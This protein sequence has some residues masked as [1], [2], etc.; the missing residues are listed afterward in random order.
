LFFKLLDFF[1]WLLS[2]LLRLLDIHLVN[3]SVLIGVIVLADVF[4]LGLWLSLQFWGGSGRLR[5]LW[6]SL[7]KADK[8]LAD[9]LWLEG[10]SGIANVFWHLNQAAL[11]DE[12]VAHANPPS[13][14]LK[15]LL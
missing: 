13:A 12:L 14:L 7:L 9:A 4:L 8:E 3:D 2:Y 6:Q 10:Q 15:V 1:L 5:L 11:V